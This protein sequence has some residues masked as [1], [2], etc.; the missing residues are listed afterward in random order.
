M[1]EPDY[2]A[3]TNALIKCAKAAKSLNLKMF[4]VQNGG[5]CFGGEGAEK[6]FTKYGVSV[7]CRGKR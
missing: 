4:A 2:K 5:Q 7:T 1:T 3:R 6:T